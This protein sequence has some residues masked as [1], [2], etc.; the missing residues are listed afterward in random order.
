MLKPGRGRSPPVR[1]AL[2]LVA[3]ALL[4]SGC[5]G[6]FLQPA[7]TLDKP[8]FD[9]TPDHGDAQTVFH[10]DAGALSKYD[11]EWEFGDGTL[12]R[13]PTADHAYGF[14][15][16]RMTITLLVTD[17]AT[18][19]QAIA[20]RDVTLGTGVN[21][22]PTVSLS[23]DS[24]WVEVGQS[25]NLSTY[26]SD[27]DRD[28]LQYDWSYASGA[29]QIVL[30]GTGSDNVAVFNASGTYDVT[31][32]ARDPKGATASDHVSIDVSK[33]IPDRTY[34][35]LYNGTL[36]VGTGGNASASEALWATPAPDTDVDSARYLYNLDYPATTILVLTWN[37][38][39][40]QGLW[41]L[42]LIVKDLDNNK[43]VMESDRSPPSPPY[44]FNFTQQD[45]GHYEVIV[46][47]VTGVQI[48]YQLLI[49]CSLDFTPAM[50]AAREGT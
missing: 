24:S 48:Q 29:Q 15:N 3:L 42:D 31:V 14:T 40:T 5:T 1:A 13:G 21:S 26:A 44:A 25:V 19:K 32:V 16:G 23:A 47:G 7:A 46:R 35:R 20:T 9:V 6:T 34:D 50:V 36:V 11:D 8:R 4:T 38:T 27:P 10:V 12:A 18:G 49:H 37:D 43:T 30:P 17:N 39:S 33:H 2:A 41:S 28:P 45:P 22:P